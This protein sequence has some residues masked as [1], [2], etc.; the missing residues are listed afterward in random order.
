MVDVTTQILIDRPRQEVAGYA[1]DPDNASAWYMNIKSVDWKTPRP[2]A[3]HSQIAFEAHFLGKLLAYVY[4]ITEWLPGERLVMQTSQS[5]FPMETTYTWETV[6]EH[7][8]KMTLRNR[9]TPIGFS[10]LFSPFMS[11][12][13]KLANQKDLERLKKL[14]ET[15]DQK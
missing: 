15:R 6:N 11:F 3:V 4:E 7:L 10:R 9:G 1:A 13:M 2:L 12:A 8:T 5:P 14:L